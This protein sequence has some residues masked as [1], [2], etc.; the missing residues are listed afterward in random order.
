MLT[1]TDDT[2]SWTVHWEDSHKAPYMNKGLQWISYDNEE[3]IRTKTG[4]AFKHN[5]AGVMVW[6]IDTDDFRGNCG[7]ATY[8]LL[9]SI[10]NALYEQEQGIASAPKPIGSTLTLAT[11]LALVLRQLLWLCHDMRIFYVTKNDSFFVP[12]TTA[13]C[14]SVY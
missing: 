2:E 4:F 12:T 8:P 13:L 3:S 11:A 1:D 6:S 14:V 10:N 9:R 7:G 5:L